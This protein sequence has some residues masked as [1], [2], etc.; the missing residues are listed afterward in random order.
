MKPASIIFLI[1]S[2][3][4]II[5]GLV[6]C[7]AG[8]N[9]AREQDVALFAT[10]VSVV[11]DDVIATDTFSGEI[12][13][14]VKIN[15][16][17]ADVRI[18]PSGTEDTYIELVNFQI[19][20]YDYSVQ[21]KMLLVDNETSIILFCTSQTAISALTVCGTICPTAPERIPKNP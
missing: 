19:G 2:V 17:D 4:I 20:T 5:A 6:L 13:N 1:V 10:D 9:L 21:N 11:G 18:E 14:K 15:L 3:I 12:I 16:S 7:T 8:V